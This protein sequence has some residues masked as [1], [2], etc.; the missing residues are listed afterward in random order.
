MT[1]A[2]VLCDA[3]PRQV[4]QRDRPLGAFLPTRAVVRRLGS[5]LRFSLRVQPLHPDLL[6][7]PAFLILSA[8]AEDIQLLP[9]GTAVAF[10]YWV[11]FCKATALKSAASWIRKPKTVDG[12]PLVAATVVQPDGE[13]EFLMLERFTF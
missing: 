8:S 6:R 11:K 3:A 5:A 4:F 12:K 10:S 13:A 1:H 2:K 9:E 7:K